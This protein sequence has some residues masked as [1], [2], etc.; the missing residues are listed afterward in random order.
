MWC[1]STA[2][3]EAMIDDVLAR[4]ERSISRVRQALLDA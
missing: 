1:T 2:M 4:T 3:D